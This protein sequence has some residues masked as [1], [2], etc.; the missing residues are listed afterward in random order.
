MPP[1]PADTPLERDL[2]A[3][4]KAYLAAQGWLVRAEVGACDALAVRGE[5]VLA[6]ELKRTLNL[7]V[8]LQAVRRQLTA[9]EVYIGVPAR[10]RTLR[11]ARWRDIVALLKRLEIGLLCVDTQTGDVQLLCQAR[12]YDRDAARR[13]AA[14]KRTALLNEFHARTGDYN[15]GG[16]QGKRITAYREAALCVARA[17]DALGTATVRQLKAQGTHAQKTSAIVRNNYYGWFLRVDK[18]RYTLTDAGRLAL[19]TYAQLGAPPAP[20]DPLPQDQPLPEGAL[21]S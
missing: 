11:S 7:D 1:T 10:P 14:T 18:M 21:Q 15:T 9:D 17:L 16:A 8:I 4:V 5:A 13:R 3:P 2:Y 12:P 19:A 6:L 20:C